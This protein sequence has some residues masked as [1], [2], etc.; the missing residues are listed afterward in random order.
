MKKQICMLSAMCISLMGIV[1]PAFASNTVAAPLEKNTGVSGM[2][3]DDQQAYSFVTLTFHDVRDDVKKRG[4]RDVYAISSKNFAQFLAWIKKNGWQPIRLEDVWQAR[5]F[6]KPLPE[7]AVLI[8]VDDGAL[9]SYTK[10]Y[11]LLKLHQVPAVFAIPTSWI[12]G[13]TKAAY[14][15]YGSGNLMSWDQMREIQRSGLVEFVSHSDNLHYGILS[16]PQKNMQPAAITRLYDEKTKSYESD[17]AYKQRIL[18]DLKRSKQVL[19]KELGV[20][21]RAIFWPYGAATKETEEIAIEA[22]FPMSFSLGSVLTLADAEKTYQRAMIMD[23]PTPEV[24]HEA[25]REFLTYTRAPY[26]QRKSIIRYDLADMAAASYEAADQKLG[27]LL[28]QVNALKTNTL[29]LKVVADSNAD[30]KIDVAYFP[31]RQLKMQQDLLNRTVWQMRTRVGHRVYAE[32]P[33]SLETQQGYSLA[34]FTTD[35]VKNNTSI[36]G[37]MLD[38]GTDL[39]CA[40]SQEKWTAACQASVQQIINIKNQ[41]QK[42]AKYYANISN[43]YQTALKVDGNQGRF[44]G[45]KQVIQLI[46]DHADFIYITIDPANASQSFTALTQ[47]IAK[48]N[49][50]ERQHLMVT[51]DIDPQANAHKW[52]HYQRAY[53][54]LREMAV[55]KIGVENYHLEAGQVIHQNLYAPL[56]LNESPLEYRDPFQAGKGR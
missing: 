52:Q 53:A 24:I 39:D 26:K 56:S 10:I 21:S 27:L 11:P 34:Q 37:L 44:D 49:D 41:T 42:A 30:G 33:L 3:Q 2:S 50:Q 18:A 5:Q 43:N 36:E 19:E 9:S 12:N 14:E 15:A 48:L 16:N 51:F 32:L 22:G 6:K 29:L 45:L 28:N 4:D 20:E 13:N 1:A 40:L 38:T 7:K 31:N 25:M 35:L 17:A 8:T 54:Q 23:N 47:T 55:Q 46:P